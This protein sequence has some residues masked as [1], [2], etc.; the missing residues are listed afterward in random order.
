MVASLVVQMVVWM[1]AL[2]VGCSAGYWADR[3]A[4]W[5]DMMSVGWSVG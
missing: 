5:K 3:K 2:M 1:D 4:A